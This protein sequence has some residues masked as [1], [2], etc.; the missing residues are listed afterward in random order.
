MDEE[1]A[2]RAFSALEHHCQENSK[3]IELLINQVELL[4][5]LLYEFESK[6]ENLYKIKLN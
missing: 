2:R 1:E 6:T 5:S 3:A 4:K